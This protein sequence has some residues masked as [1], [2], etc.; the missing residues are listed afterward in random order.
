MA[1]CTAI[2]VSVAATPPCS[3]IRFYKESSP[4]H[5]DSDR[6]VA[7]WA[8]QGLLGGVGDVA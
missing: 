6:G 7:R 1:Q 3:A 2:G 5:S 4:R 8:P